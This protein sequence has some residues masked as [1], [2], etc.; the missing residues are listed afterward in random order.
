MMKRIL[1]WACALSLPC[2]LLAEKRVFLGVGVTETSDVLRSQLAIPGGLVV[3]AVSEDGPS[4]DR[5]EQADVL[6]R[7]NDQLLFNKEQL[8][9]LLQTYAVGTEVKVALV[10]S[11]EEKTV[12]IVLQETDQV[13]TKAEKNSEDL[14]ERLREIHGLS[15]K[16]R[17]VD[18][19]I[20][21]IKQPENK[22]LRS[23]VW[24]EDGKTYVAASSEAKGQIQIKGPS[25]IVYLGKGSL[26]D[27]DQ[28]SQVPEKFRKRIKAIQEAKVKAQHAA[29]RLI[30]GS[31]SAPTEIGQ[32]LDDVKRLIDNTLESAEE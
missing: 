17:G 11:G 26:D 6:I 20:N 16:F 28:N 27:L 8:V 21:K 23:V 1:L 3:T 31:N 25:K 5:I 14:I 10:R 2:T 4:T 32:E 24:V 9:S 13:A 30:T 19:D 29:E 7:V 12:S 22:A 15:T 18:F